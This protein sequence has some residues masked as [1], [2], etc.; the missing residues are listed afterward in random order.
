MS[1]KS[2][3]LYISHF[4]ISITEVSGYA[5]DV[6]A[7]SERLK[8][9]QSELETFGQRKTVLQS[10]IKTYGDRDDYVSKMVKA[11]HEMP[12]EQEQEKVKRSQSK[13]ITVYMP[14][15]GK[16]IPREL[17]NIDDYAIKHQCSLYD[18]KAN[19]DDM[20]EV[21]TELYKTHTVNEGDVVTVSR[22][23]TAYYHK[24][25]G[26]WHVSDFMKSR[27]EL[28]RK[29]QEELARQEQERIAAEERRRQQEEERRKREE[30]KAKQKS[31]PKKKKDRS[32]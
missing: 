32:L 14:A 6:A 3:C 25:T 16:E 21:L 8:E 30:E 22:D 19:P 12:D 10:I 28:E 29:R 11:T 26:F 7:D 9:M 17:V 18:L 24:D 27:A 13:T 31:A 23:D 1:N 5:D 4:G 20:R 15:N 2:G